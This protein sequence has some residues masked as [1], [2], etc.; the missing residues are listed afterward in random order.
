MP[1]LQK[2]DFTVKRANKPCTSQ[3]KIIENII[4][5]ATHVVPPGPQGARIAI[6]DAHIAVIFGLKYL[7]DKIGCT[8]SF[9]GRD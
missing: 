6:I 4:S 2:I 5:I 1:H 8:L 7:N 9:A 3:I